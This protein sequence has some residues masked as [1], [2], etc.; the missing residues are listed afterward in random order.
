VKPK[1][2]KTKKPEKNLKT[3]KITMI[4]LRKKQEKKSSKRMKKKKL[5]LPSI[6]QLLF[7]NK[8]K[9]VRSPPYPN[10]FEYPN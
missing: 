4:K 10:N 1:K 6:M 5:I 8:K 2:N 3:T 7:A 9:A